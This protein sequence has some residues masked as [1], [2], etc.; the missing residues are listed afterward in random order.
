MSC[1]VARDDLWEWVHGD[2]ESDSDI[3]RHVA[4]CADCSSAVSQMSKLMADVR[5]IGDRDE[6]AGAA[7]PKTI[8]E[9]RVIDKIGEGGMGIVFEAEQQSPRRRVALKVVRAGLISD[10]FQT[11][12][13]HR[14]MQ[15]LARLNHPAIASIYDAGLTPDGQRYFA[16]ELVEG[17]RLDE[18]VAGR[19]VGQ[20]AQP[21][22]SPRERWRLF[23]RICEAISYA[24][25][26][27]V[28]HRDLK[29]AN[30]LITA[31]GTPKI[32]DFGLARAAADDPAMTMVSE[33]GRLL[34]TPAYMSPEQTLADPHAIDVRSDVYTLGIMLYELTTGTFPYDVRQATIVDICKVITDARPRAPRAINRLV[35]ADIETIILKALEK[36]P[37][38]RYGSVGEFA[39]DVQRFL[40]NHPI[41]ARPPSRAYQARKLVQ[42]HKLPFALL[43]TILLLAVGSAVV[44]AI[45]KQQV[46]RERDTARTE[47]DK[48]RRINNILTTFLNASNSWEQ[49]SSDTTVKQVLDGMS[50]RIEDEL[51]DSPEL[52]A[53]I[54]HTLG[55][56]Y[57]MLSD[58]E[59]AQL[60]LRFAYDTRMALLGENN[61]ETLDA[62]DDLG[63]LY[64]EAGQPDQAEALLRRALVGRRKVLGNNHPDTAETLN[65]IGVVSKTSGQLDAAQGHFEQALATRQRYADKLLADPRATHKDRRDAH[66]AVAQTRNNLA[67]LFRAR[68]AAVPGDRE[69]VRQFWR[70]AET[71]YLAALELR[72]QWLGDHPEVGKMHNNYAKLLND[73]GKRAAAEE[74]L[75][76]GLEILERTVGR[77]HAYTARTLYNLAEILLAEGEIEPAEAL[78]RQALALQEELLD[79]DHGAL[80]QTQALLQQIENRRIP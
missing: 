22:L 46:A 10:E 68:A 26:R 36:E 14:E 64:H 50:R 32:L 54:R 77:E 44:F 35:P 60:H 58:Y 27:G 63:E 39:D 18:Y 80:A 9:Y 29:P 41:Q 28:I 1:G 75:R 57:R 66:N 71:H 15:T 31:D 21:V 30:V 3:G 73:M 8:G 76:A 48:F 19:R 16:M 69:A 45:Q 51:S 59:N 11:K 53:T 78:C 61:P 55:M 37:E 2:R 12:L 74:H 40:D 79:P 43:S 56:T 47:A 33:A 4:T 34:G 17:I 6:G 20:D 65:S 13:F 67:A 7:L 25:Q 49:G 5:E 62:L 24:H 42:R 52:A 72:T 38:R 23:H 70:Q